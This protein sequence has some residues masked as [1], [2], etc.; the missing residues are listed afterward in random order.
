MY[1]IDFVHGPIGLQSIHFVI[2]VEVRL[3][4][5]GRSVLSADEYYR[6]RKKIMMLIPD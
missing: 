6:I 3:T 2:G 4:F 1:K 5:D